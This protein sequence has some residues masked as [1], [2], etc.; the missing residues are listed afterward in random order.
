MKKEEK[1]SSNRQA[2]W[3]QLGSTWKNQEDRVKL[4]NSCGTWVFNVSKRMWARESTSRWWQKGGGAYSSCKMVTGFDYTW[5]LSSNI[6]TSKTFLALNGAFGKRGPLKSQRDTGNK[7]K[8]DRMKERKMGGE[9][10]N[11]ED[12]AEKQEIRE[13]VEH[14]A[15]KLVRWEE[16]QEEIKYVNESTL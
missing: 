6:W 10:Q 7:W 9:N 16:L 12:T 2:L 13:A 3:L 5:V 15:A 8:L 14:I 4:H 11:S 1:A